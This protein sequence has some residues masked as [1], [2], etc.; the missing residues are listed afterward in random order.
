MSCFTL[1]ISN[2]AELFKNVLMDY[3]ENMRLRFI[4]T[5]LLIFISCSI[6]FAA[7]ANY[8]DLGLTSKTLWATC[9]VGASSPEEYGDFFAWTLA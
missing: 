5:T 7:S 2:F 4:I 9:N 1:L 6:G 8:V 3:S